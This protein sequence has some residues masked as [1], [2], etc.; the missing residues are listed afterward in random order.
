[1]GAG[2][3][4]RDHT[5]AVCVLF[6]LLTATDRIR[7]RVEHASKARKNMSSV[8]VCKKELSAVPVLGRLASHSA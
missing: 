1:M 3:A 8:F 2:P 5:R 6:L 7:L 4:G